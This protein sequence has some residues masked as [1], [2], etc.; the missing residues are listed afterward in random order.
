MIGVD[1]GCGSNGN[2]LFRFYELKALIRRQKCKT[3]REGLDS[4]LG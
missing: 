4:A 2:F 1:S 3:N